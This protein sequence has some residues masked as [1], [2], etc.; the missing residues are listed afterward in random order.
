VTGGAKGI[1][2]AIVESLA[3]AGASV[4]FTYHTSVNAQALVSALEQAGGKALAVAMDVKDRQAV[5][6]GVETVLKTFGGLEILVNNAGVT[7][8]GLL[9]R[10][11]ESDWDLVL[12]T[13][14]KGTFH[15]TQAV[16]RTMVRQRYGRIINI[17]SVVGAMGSAGQGNYAASKAGLM[18]FTK[19]MARE[20]A[21]R[22]I[23]VNAVAPGFIETDMTRGLAEERRAYLLAQIPLG[24]FGGA[25]EVARCVRFLADPD[26][27]Y[28]S[29]QV[30]HVNGG[31]YL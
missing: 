8:D 20:L 11:K 25:E 7:R 1:G 13:N 23:T 3:E 4:A 30:I 18:G 12:D 2:R 17:T 6:A 14:L 21:S 27:G 9:L 28:I 5:E 16:A 26:M 24:R 19:S 29:G 31:M 15:C 22:G 10:M